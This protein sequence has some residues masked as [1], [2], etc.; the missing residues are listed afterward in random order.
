MRTG[1]TDDRTVS[2]IS[3]RKYVPRL[4]VDEWAAIEGFV[5]AAVQ[6]CDGHIPHSARSL[7]GSAAQLALWAWRNGLPLELD[8]VFRRST[9]G[10]F[11]AKGCDGLAK[12]TRGTYRSRLLRMG[13]VL[14]PEHQ[15]QH[16][17][18][19]RPDFK[20]LPYTHAEQASLRSWAA[21]QRT[22][23]RRADAKI[24]LA[25]G[26]GAGLSGGEI[27]DLRRGHVSADVAGVLV[28][29]IGR[30]SRTVPVLMEWEGSLA[31]VALSGSDPES[32]VFR[33]DAARPNANVVAHFMRGA[34]NE[35]STSRMRT[36]WIV[37]H[38]AAGVPVKALVEAAGVDGLTSLQRCMEHL[39]LVEHAFSRPL[40][41][42]PGTSH[43]RRDR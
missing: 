12:T 24:L 18:G 5:L 40:L 2:A 21:G 14:A 36:T 29:V 41:R 38:L 27:I 1:P 4:P 15:N 9:V 31:A 23:A 34:E 35:P 28:K 22:S 16:L 19:I 10:L 17:P 6:A 32:F 13:E 43:V 39:P 37:K 20:A 26:L 25:L 8:V 42:G 11:I 30:R 3:T 33:P 7:S